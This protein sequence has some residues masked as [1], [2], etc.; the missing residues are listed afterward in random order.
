[1][2]LKF[3]LNSDDVFNELNELD[4]DKRA[5]M[6]GKVVNKHT[7]YNLCFSNKQQVPDYEQGKGIIIKYN[8]VQIFKKIKKIYFRYW[9]IGR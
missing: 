3:D 9:Q 2:I 5:L 7:R 6:Y 4:W 1:M 8:N